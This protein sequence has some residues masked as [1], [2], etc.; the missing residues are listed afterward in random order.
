MNFCHFYLSLVAVGV[1]VDVASIGVGYFGAVIQNPY[2]RCSGSEVVVV[3]VILRT[4]KVIVII[5]VGMVNY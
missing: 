3:A 5:V 1:S 2:S 4:D